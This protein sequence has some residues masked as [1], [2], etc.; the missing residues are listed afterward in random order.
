MSELD[1]VTIHDEERA[2]LL[3]MQTDVCSMPPSPEELEIGNKIRAALKTLGR[4]AIGIAAPQ[5]GYAKMIFGMNTPN[6]IV[7][8]F[9]PAILERSLTTT[10]DREGCL[11]IPNE[12]ANVRRSNIV[13]LSYFDEM[14]GYQENVFSGVLARCCQHEIDHLR[15]TTILQHVVTEN[16]RMLKF[17]K[18]RKMVKEHRK[19]KNRV[20]RR[21]AKKSRQKNRN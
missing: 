3:L 10:L 4:R 5:L 16:E 9:N 11:S 21:M 1:L 8:C 14:G 13:R 12:L 7:V 17:Q 19:C 6:G 18:H 20:K 2:G 15:G